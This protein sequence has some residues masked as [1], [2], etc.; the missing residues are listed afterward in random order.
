M[1]LASSNTPLSRSRDPGDDFETISTPF[2]PR[3]VRRI[4]VPD[5]DESKPPSRDVLIQREVAALR[6]QGKV[7]VGIKPADS[8]A[9]AK[10][11]REYRGCASE[12]LQR[13]VAMRR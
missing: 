4:K 6:L 13:P 10:Q 9:N 5:W 1:S 11:V 3:R 2:G 8:D 12:P 7:G